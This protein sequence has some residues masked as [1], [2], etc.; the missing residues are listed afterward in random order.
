MLGIIPITPN[1][2][3]ANTVLLL[4]KIDIVIMMLSVLTEFRTAIGF[5]NT[6]IFSVTETTRLLMIATGILALIRS[7]LNL[8]IGIFFIMWLRRAYH[9]LHKAGSQYLRH[10]EGWA[11][12]AWFVPFLNLSW[13]LQIVRDVWIETQNVFRKKGEIY[14]QEEDRI[15]GWWWMM[16]LVPIIASYV[17]TFAMKNQAFEI[18][19]IFT[20]F[21]TL[22]YLL[23]AFL[24]ISLIK[25]I[26][27]M[28]TEMLDRAHQYYQWQNQQYSENLR[29]QNQQEPI[30]HQPNLNV[31]QQD[32][33]K[34]EKPDSTPPQDL[35]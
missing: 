29:E 32:F 21:G 13:P 3:R 2:Q 35:G 33:Y 16:Y 25:R 20:A 10:S 9:N 34:P 5:H 24:A 22:G 7:V 27:G 30:S 26:S 23:D 31:Q 28:E 4:F 17:G 14:E 18:A 11:A 15:S 8:I 6:S 19:Y 12:G 1:E